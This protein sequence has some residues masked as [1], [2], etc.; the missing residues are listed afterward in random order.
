MPVTSK[1][2]KISE[3]GLHHC[4]PQQLPV[5]NMF[6]MTPFPLKTVSDST[7]LSSEGNLHTVR[8]STA[9]SSEGKLH[10]VS[11]SAALS[12]EGNLHTVSDSTAVS[13]EGNLI[14]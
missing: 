10:M 1:E 9:L 5:L 2:I 3:N 12:S 13:S 4:I 7:A 8:D 6:H 11:D 14:Q